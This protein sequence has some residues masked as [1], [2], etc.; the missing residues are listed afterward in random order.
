MG[1]GGV[2][3]SQTPETYACYVTHDMGGD[4]MVV[5]ANQKRVWSMSHD[6]LPSDH[7][8]P[9]QNITDRYFIIINKD[10]FLTYTMAAHQR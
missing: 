5:T 3:K 10:S 4:I 1:E 6:L 7:N 9:Q 8:S 2:R